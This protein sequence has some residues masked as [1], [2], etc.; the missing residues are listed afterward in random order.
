MLKQNYISP[1][2]P[3]I[4]LPKET[5]RT[6]KLTSPDISL[7]KET[8]RTEKLTINYVKTIA[9]KILLLKSIL[10]NKVHFKKTK[11]G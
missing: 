1:N 8:S 9:T 5:S 7:P 4:S 2:S 3:D 11:A 6:D 10:K